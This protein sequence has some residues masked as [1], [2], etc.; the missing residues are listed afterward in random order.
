[1]VSNNDNKHNE[2]HTN[3]NTKHRI[4]WHKDR[5]DDGLQKVAKRVCGPERDEEVLELLEKP[6]GTAPEALSRVKVVGSNPAGPTKT[7][8]CASKQCPCNLARF[9]L[10]S[11]CLRTTQVLVFACNSNKGKTDLQKRQNVCA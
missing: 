2:Q 7:F 9:E 3:N 4:T 10:I 6:V 11:P 5:Y 1:M 8:F